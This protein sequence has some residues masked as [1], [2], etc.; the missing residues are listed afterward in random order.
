MIDELKK[1]VNDLE[2]DEAKSLLFHLL[3]RVKMFND[4]VYPN[5]EV[6][7]SLQYTTE[8]FISMKTNT[9]TPITSDVVHIVFGDSPKG[10]LGIALD[11]KE[12]IISLPTILSVGPLFNLHNPSG[13]EVRFNWFDE[14]FVKEDQDEIVLFKESFKQ[15]IKDIESIP[16]NQS[17]MIWMGENAHEQIGL[18]LA[19]Y[20]LKEKKHSIYTINTSLAYETFA[21]KPDILYTVR[22]MGELPPEKLAQFYSTKQTAILLSKEERQSL[23]QDWEQL[24]MT[25]HVLRIWQDR[26]IRSVDCHFYDNVLIGAAQSLHEKRQNTN[27]MKSARLIGEVIGHLEQYIGDEF[28]EYRLRMLIEKGVFEMKGSLKA[29]RYYDVRL[30]R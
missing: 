29:M 2:E 30:N 14:H 17:V 10:S 21:A 15:S 18:R 27:F 13:I 5:D 20:L 3:Y 26:H 16:E 22:H 23:E 12:P 11:G 6:I 1:L 8:G 9:P 24:A 28:L 4:P 7:K 25:E 19:V